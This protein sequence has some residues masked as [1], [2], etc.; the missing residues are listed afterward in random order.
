MC[1][2]MLQSR[3]PFGSG[4]SG[5]T[6]IDASA[7]EHRAG[8]E[9]DWTPIHEWAS[10]LIDRLVGDQP[11]RHV[12]IYVPDRG[13]DGLRLVGQAWGA[14][15]EAGDIVVG[16][17]IVPF[18]GSVTGRV[19]RTGAPALCADS[20][21]DPDYRHYPGG[22]SRSFLTVPVRYDGEVLA[23]I[24]VEAPWTGAFSIRDFDALA[25][26]AVACAAAF[27]RPSSAAL[28]S[29]SVHREAPAAND[30]AADERVPQRR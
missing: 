9:P 28:T 27:P 29:G 12:G 19:Y 10:R 21:L 4:R 26:E 11:T 2:V 22:R 5:E 23:V 14:G 3:R 30:P 1:G 20:S 15:E 7:S 18:F 8:V 25:A 6:T 24:N 16:E 17:W 13:A